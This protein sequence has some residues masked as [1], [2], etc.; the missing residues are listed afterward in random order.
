MGWKHARRSHKRPLFINTKNRKR[1]PFERIERMLDTGSKVALVG[2]ILL[3]ML[4]VTLHHL[5]IHN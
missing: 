4:L 3:M 5:G 2:G 1:D